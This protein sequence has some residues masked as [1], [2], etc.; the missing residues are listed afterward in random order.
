[1]NRASVCGLFQAPLRFAL[2]GA[3]SLPTVDTI[4][5]PPRP[6]RLSLDGTRRL[7]AGAALGSSTQPDTRRACGS[8][9]SE[10]PRSWEAPGQA[11]TDKPSAMAG[12]LLAA[13]RLT[14]HFL[15]S[16]QGATRVFVSRMVGGAASGV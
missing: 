4:T 3:R 9:V 8:S 12:S 13:S 16:P 10:R 14:A 7:P 1:M 6:R 5:M 15:K 2:E 11:L